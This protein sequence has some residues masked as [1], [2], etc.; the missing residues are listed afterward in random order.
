MERPYYSTNGDSL[1]GRTPPGMAVE[2]WG[3]LMQE[4]PR[5]EEHRV[6]NN[7]LASLC[8]LAGEEGI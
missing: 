1:T 3:R 6:E 2:E 8:W 5:L 4:M 7:P